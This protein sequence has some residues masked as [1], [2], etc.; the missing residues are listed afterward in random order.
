VI[1][2]T[3]EPHQ[4]VPPPGWSPEIFE[5]VTDA[6]AAALVAALLRERTEAQEMARP[7]SIQPSMERANLAAE[8]LQGPLRGAV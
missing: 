1:V 8:C 2:A 7:T 6:L 5:R 3:L 4:H